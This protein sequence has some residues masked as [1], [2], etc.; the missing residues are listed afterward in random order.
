[1]DSEKAM[2]LENQVLPQVFIQ[3]IYVSPCHKIYWFIK[4][5][6]LNIFSLLVTNFL[7]FLQYFLKNG[8]SCKTGNI[9]FTMDLCTTTYKNIQKRTQLLF[10]DVYTHTQKYIV[11]YKW[12]QLPVLH[13]KYIHLGGTKYLYWLS[14]KNEIVILA[15]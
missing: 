14:D 9:L 2:K 6:I 10:K 7:Y 3:S 13:W 15:F 5:T 1:M 8:I 4:L 11:K 12:N